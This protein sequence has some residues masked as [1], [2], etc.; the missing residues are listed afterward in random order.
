MVRDEEKQILEAI[1]AEFLHRDWPRYEEFRVQHEAQRHL[2][3]AMVRKGLLHTDESYKLT[4]LGL[5]HAANP[6][7]LNLRQHVRD[8]VLKL[9]EWYRAAPKQI[10]K[11][12]TTSD[13]W[14]NDALNYKALQLLSPLGSFSF[15]CN[16]FRRCRPCAG[17]RAHS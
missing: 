17:Q 10:Y 1:A 7:G 2:L 11:P 3:D 6:E 9:K 15:L 8:A 14:L 4:L 5:A 16:T 12:S 13:T